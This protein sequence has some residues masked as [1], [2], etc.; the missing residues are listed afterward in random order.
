MGEIDLR[1]AI[2][3]A[4]GGVPAVFVAAFIVK[5][6]PLELLRWMVIVVVFYAALMMLRAAAIGRR[7][8]MSLT[9]D[10]A[11]AI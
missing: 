1:L 2:G 4:I 6:M 5:S 11:A 3:M 9:A 8:P 7:Q 10:R